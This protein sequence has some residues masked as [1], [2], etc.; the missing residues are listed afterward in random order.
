[1]H[2]NERKTYVTEIIREMPAISLISLP[3]HKLNEM[4]NEI[5]SEI[6]RTRLALRWIQGV[7][8]IKAIQKGGFDGK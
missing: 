3:L 7:K 2:N 1:M 8:R 6:R 5:Y 4:E